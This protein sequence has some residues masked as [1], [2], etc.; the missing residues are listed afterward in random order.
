MPSNPTTLGAWLRESR[1]IRGLTLTGIARDAGASNQ[2]NLSKAERGAFVPEAATMD[3]LAPFYGSPWLSDAQNILVVRAIV[4]VVSGRPGY[5]PTSQEELTTTA[6]VKFALNQAEAVVSAWP[7]A[8]EDAQRVVH[9]YSVRFPHV[10]GLVEVPWPEARPFWV[11][12]WLQQALYVSAAH[13]RLNEQIRPTVN[14]DDDEARTVF[15]ALEHHLNSEKQLLQHWDR[16]AVVRSAASEVLSTL[17]GTRAHPWFEYPALDDPE[18]PDISEYVA[19]DSLLL[20][21]EDDGDD[22]HWNNFGSLVRVLRA[23]GALTRDDAA[24]A[25]QELDSWA[26]LLAAV[27][28]Q[29]RHAPALREVIEQLVGYPYPPAYRPEAIDAL[30]V[31]LS[32]VGDQR[33]TLAE[34]LATLAEFTA[35]ARPSASAPEDDLPFPFDDDL[36]F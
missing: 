12:I 31:L 35:H 24:D 21:P 19:V 32:R 30:A 3:K 13:R 26:R 23:E 34:I 5:R 17:T 7:E 36:P 18:L 4:W 25:T 27:I 20:D 11:W 16:W 14:W 22:A 10:P 28:R 29:S 15:H 8:P 2:S 9:G 33:A 6:N 1:Q